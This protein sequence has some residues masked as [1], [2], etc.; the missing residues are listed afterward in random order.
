[1][2]TMCENTHQ[3]ETLVTLLCLSSYTHLNIADYA[4]QEYILL[5]QYD[6]WDS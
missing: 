4:L 3:V 5:L 6:K 2:S 1:M